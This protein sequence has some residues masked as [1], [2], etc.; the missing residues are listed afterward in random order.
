MSNHLSSSLD[1]PFPFVTIHFRFDG[2]ED[3]PSGL[4]GQDGLLKYF[5]FLINL[6]PVWFIP[7]YY[8][9]G[10]YLYGH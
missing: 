5:I 10:Q 6:L 8:F 7:D 1:K 4:K 3:L 2:S 9:S